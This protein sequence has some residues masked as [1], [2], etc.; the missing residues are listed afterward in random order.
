MPFESG[1]FAR[2]GCQFA[3]MFFDERRRA[4]AEMHRVLQPGGCLAVA[5][6]GRLEET[7]GYA[8]MS[9][10]LE[11]LFDREIAAELRPRCCVPTSHRTTGAMCS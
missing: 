3:L 5:V 6:W 2:V 9:E 1:R 8:A 4:M 7:P 10:L 11:R